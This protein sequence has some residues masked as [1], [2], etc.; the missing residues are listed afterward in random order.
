MSKYLAV[1]TSTL[2]MESD[3]DLKDYIEEVNAKW[4]DIEPDKVKALAENGFCQL[5]DEFGETMIV[6]KRVVENE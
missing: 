6:I 1:V 3:D 5:A 2:H 4:G